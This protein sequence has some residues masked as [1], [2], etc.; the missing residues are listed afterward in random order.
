MRAGDVK[1]LGEAGGGAES[2]VGAI[3]IG[4][5]VGDEDR[6]HQQEPS[7]PQFDA[8]RARFAGFWSQHRRFISLCAGSGDSAVVGGAMRDGGI[9]ANI[10]TGPV[11]VCLYGVKCNSFRWLRHIQPYSQ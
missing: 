6:G 9:R 11:T 4:E 3:E 1:G 5:A 7:P 10:H 2:V 8:F